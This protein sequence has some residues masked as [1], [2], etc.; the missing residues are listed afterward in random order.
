MTEKRDRVKKTRDKIK[1]KTEKELD[2]KRYI[3]KSFIEKK[4]CEKI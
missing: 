4:Y 3:I 2:K 1:K